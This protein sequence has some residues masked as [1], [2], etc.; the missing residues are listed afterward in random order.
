MA[1]I[2]ARIDSG[3]EA[4]GRALFRNRIKVL[5]L[6]SALVSGLMSQLPGLTADN[7]R[8]SFFR[9]D[10]P[11]LIEY[12]AF[13]DQFGRQ[14]L[15]VILVSPQEVF[16]RA[17][18]EK[19]TALHSA[20]EEEVPYLAEVTSLVNVR[21]TRGEADELIV[22]DLLE[23]LPADA[24]AMA[25]LKRRVLS[26]SL[27]PNNFIS[28]NGRHTALLVDL[29]A[30][31]P[32]GSGDDLLGGFDN[33]APEGGAGASAGSEPLSAAEISESIVAIYGIM[34][35]F[36]APDFQLGLAGNPVVT[37]FINRKIPSE[38]AFFVALAYVLFSIFLFIL[39]RRASGVVIPL[40]VAMLS[41]PSAFS[42]MAIFGAPFT[43]I[44][45]ILPSFLTAVSVGSSVHLLAVFYRHYQQNGDKEGAVVFAM[46]HSGMP[47]FMT[48]LTTAAGLFSFSA[49]DLAPVANLGRFGGA[50]VVLILVYTLVVIPPL[51][52]L[53]PIRRYPSFAGRHPGAGIDRVLTGIADFATRRALGVVVASAVIV[54]VAASGLVWQRFGHDTVAW[55]PRS[56]EIR[57]AVDRID[58]EL[59]GVYS[60]EV[61][62][63]TGRE[64]GLYEP[65]AMNNLEALGQFA[66]AYRNENGENFVGK[67]LS[68]VNVLKETHKALNENRDEFYAIPQRRELIAQ[69]LLLFENS[70]S[71][72]LERLVDPQFSQA[73]F[74]ARVLR[75][76]AA[77][78][79]DFVRE[80]GGEAR[81]LFGREAEVT[82]TGALKLLTETIHLVMLSVAESY[83]IAFLVITVLMILL[84]GSVR[85]GLLSMLPNL[86][87]IV[88]ALGVMG[89]M[90]I[91]M[92]MANMLLGTTAL[93]LA[94][95]D[96][97]HFFHNFRRYYVRSGSAAEATRETMLTTG[98]AM[99]FT[100]IV[101]VTGYWVFMA[102][103]LL[104]L[105][106]FGFIMGV[107]L[108]IALLA[109]LF[110]AP[111]MMELINRTGR[112]RRLMGRWGKAE[113]PA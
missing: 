101:L 91:P 99:L 84:L 86:A 100:T 89:W 53:L 12:N 46:G 50:G 9:P 90:G 75:D 38:V 59:K 52:A 28:E 6:V 74:S 108:I 15:L 51:L 21:D 44:T 57:Q 35:R 64:N 81:R 93:G 67:T 92:D 30:Y 54:A 96:T 22:A 45:S 103:T 31:S 62:I 60:I 102:A 40:L 1:T 48:S 85:F 112:G 5:L 39:F 11:N 79:V 77:A 80:L 14:D 13:R 105:V 83:A 69:E 78:Y 61:V 107:T 17:F 63:D 8:E 110:L 66:E 95:D 33:G 106:Q 2:R 32:Q 41:L 73:R 27:Y 87:P 68:I 82:V 70:G 25:A 104:N 109:D 71:D 94:V 65:A 36:E 24:R 19:L 72:D 4:F 34:A 113:V 76:D 88:V 43:A 55:L 47:I 26:H 7:S 29:L 56:L 49:T 58:R 23:T 42:L 98:R 18:M 10:D 111:A 3:F 97:I 37:D 16:D 20:I